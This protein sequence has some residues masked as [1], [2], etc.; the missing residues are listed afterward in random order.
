MKRCPSARL[1]PIAVA[2][3]APLAA[4]P[5]A[6]AE[7]VIRR[8]G[9]AL[10]LQGDSSTVNFD[11]ST[12]KPNMSGVAKRVIA[13]AGDHFEWITV[14]LTFLDPDTKVT[15]AYANRIRNEVVGLGSRV[16]VQDL[17]AN[18]GSNGVLRTMINMSSTRI[19]REGGD[20]DLTT[21]GQESGH[22]WIAALD[23][24][25]PRTGAIW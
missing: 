10:L 4:A 2:A 24:V 8:V 16:M 15:G 9:E 7:G 19:P 21:W 14:F 18:Y 11:G 12:Y 6:R 1:V 22:R 23:W 13:E 20:W 3:L 17:S 5:A 25:D